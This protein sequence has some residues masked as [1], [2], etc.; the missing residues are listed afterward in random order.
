MK[1]ILI[2]SVA[3]VLTALGLCI[4]INRDNYKYFHFLPSII[5]Q[6]KSSI[7][8]EDSK[9]I[10]KS[11]EKEYIVL[12]RSNDFCDIEP[13][14][15]W[16]EKQ[17]YCPNLLGFIKKNK[18][19]DAHFLNIRSNVKSIDSDFRFYLDYKIKYTYLSSSFIMNAS[20][21]SIQEIYTDFLPDTCY[22]YLIRSRNYNKESSSN[23]QYD[24]IQRFLLANKENV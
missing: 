24:T 14:E 6:K 7:S 9:N 16:I 3:I 20:D 2:V 15:I 8:V 22:L 21:I 17:W 1:R 19:T 23:Q 12:A 13:T 18:E 4:F 11:F 5:Q 10:S